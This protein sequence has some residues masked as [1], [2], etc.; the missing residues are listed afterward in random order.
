VENTE[1]RAAL[2]QH[3]KIGTHNG[4][5]TNR[6]N[7]SSAAVAQLEKNYP[8]FDVHIVRLS[9]PANFITSAPEHKAIAT[10]RSLT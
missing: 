2:K 6:D 4:A 10:A 9:E 5:V 1:R 3:R 8:L 7:L